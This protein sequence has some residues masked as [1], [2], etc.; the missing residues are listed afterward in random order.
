MF[1]VSTI[2]SARDFLELVSRTPLSTDSFLQSFGK[3]KF[4][5]AAKV[6]QVVTECG[7]VHININGFIVAS[8]RGKEIAQLDYQLAL[9]IQLED[10]IQ[11]YNPTWASL[12]PKGREEAINF[13]PDN[14]RQCFKE[15]GFCGEM[16][17]K[18]IDIW[19]R[20]ALAYRNFN[21]QQML[22]TGRMGE[23]LSLKYE[24]ERTG[25][26]PIWQSIESNLC[27]F[28]ILSIADKNISSK[29]L[30]E[31]KATSSKFASAYLYI[32]K[33]EWRTANVSKNYCFHLWVLK[34]KP[35]LYVASV[36]DVE[37]HISQNAGQGEWQSVRIPFMAVV[38]EEQP[39][40]VV[41]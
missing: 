36:I 41:Q 14:V 21:Q 9:L 13:L 20:L 10:M 11:Q 3:F 35:A 6:L 1:S 26:K 39:T 4:E 19:D 27:G 30:I 18:L 34:D 29:L 31:V 15:A 8:D 28:D 23:R 12:L 37:K 7:W 22:D 16:T 40:Y 2:Y 25:E 5:S 38:N 33:N 32:S 24:L 17:S